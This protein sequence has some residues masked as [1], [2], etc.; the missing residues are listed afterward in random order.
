LFREKL[1]PQVF[2]VQRVKM[3]KM[4][5]LENLVQM[6]FQVLQEKG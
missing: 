4:D 1:V 6:D 2:Q 5:H 3:A